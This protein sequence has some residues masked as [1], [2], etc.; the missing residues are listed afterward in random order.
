MQLGP[1]NRGMGCTDEMD[2]MCSL[3]GPLGI[4][5]ALPEHLYST[6]R[7]TA[8]TDTHLQHSCRHILAAGCV[9]G[10]L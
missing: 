2:E 10:V 8:P 4:A 9:P 3:R 5:S 6:P 7:P 1:T